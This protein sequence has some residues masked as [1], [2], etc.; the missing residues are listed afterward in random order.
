MQIVVYGIEETDFRCAGCREAKR[1]FSEA[2]LEID[3][4]RIVKS[5]DGYPDYDKEVMN[6]LRKRISFT[7]LILPYIFVDD[8][9]IKIK[10]LKDFL[11]SKGYDVD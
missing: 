1:L 2:G 4:K 9:Y 11:I 7:K 8:E 5:I 6:D 3:F 10:D